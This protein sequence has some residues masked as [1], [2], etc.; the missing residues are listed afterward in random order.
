MPSR[1]QLAAAAAWIAVL[2]LV[3]WSAWHRWQV[4]TSTPY[5]VGIDGY[6]YSIQVRA[7]AEHGHLAYPAAP[8]TFWLMGLASSLTDPI[9]G[10]KLVAALAGALIGVPAFL[11]GRRLGGAA[12][13]LAAAV[14]AVTSGGSF[15]LSLEFVK[16]GVGLTV[17]LTALWLGIRALEAP[18]RVRLGAFGAGALAAALTHKMAGALVVALLAPAIVVELHARVG[19][20][21]TVRLAAIG[22]G[23]LAAVAIVLGLVAPARFLAGRDLAAAGALVGGDAHWSLP[24]MAIPHPGRPTFTLALGDQALIALAIALVWIGLAIAARVTGARAPADGPRPAERALAWAAVGLVL[25]TALPV[26]AIGDPD[27]LGF[28]LRV[29]VFAPAAIVAAAVA[30]RALAALAP[31]LRV[32]AIAPLLVVRVVTAEPEP[33]EGMVVAHP[34]LVAGM[35]ALRDRLPADAV[36][37]TSER[38]LGFMAAWYARVPVRLRPDPVPPARRWRLL[39]GNLIQLGSPLDDA[40]RAARAQPSLAPPIALHPRDPDGLIVVPEATWD[41]VLDQ[42]PARL[43]AYWR[44]WHT[45]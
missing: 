42:L 39:A 2:G 6:F 33:T 44:A 23:I 29:A 38:H 10:P 34:A 25:V 5:P 8:L 18:T 13:G 20:A 14:V 3:A 30:G 32:A 36:V 12:G 22:A 21:R 11:L 43:A 15:F 19:R 31:W 16:N 9:T 1:S 37:I 45:R 35:Q 41:W 26:L 17:A 28:R 7:L 27:G 24:A 4:L 40:L